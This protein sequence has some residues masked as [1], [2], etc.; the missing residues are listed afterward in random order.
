MISLQEVIMLRPAQHYTIKV[1]ERFNPPDGVVLGNTFRLQVLQPVV[2]GKA[3]VS[4]WTG[5]SGHGKSLLLNQLA[6]DLAKNDVKVAIMSLEMAP[7]RTLHRMIRQ[8]VGSKDPDDRLIFKAMDW[9]GRNIWVNQDTGTSKLDPMLKVFQQM[10]GD[11]GISHFMIDSLLKLGLAED[12]YN[13]QKFLV[14]RLQ[15][16]AHSNGVHVHLVAH[17]RK[18][19]DEA[20][21]PG[22]F[23]VRGAAGIT[24][25]ADNVLSVWRN[26]K[27]EL[28]IQKN[29]SASD[30]IN[31]PAAVLD[32]SKH[33][34]LGGDVEGRYLLH[35]HKD[36]MQFIQRQND[37]PF[38][39]VEA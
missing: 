39:Y 9:L 11:Y 10:A 35:F 27:R 2:F 14:D 30:Q 29:G 28:D 19:N 12:A 18:G 20:S 24:D 33:R 8:A 21:I 1:I 25:L 7:D 3:E 38:Y 13:E 5:I 23:D 34:E 17:A 37:R 22:K 15:R 6:L 32:V 16:F 36:S 31:Q 26:K 4:I